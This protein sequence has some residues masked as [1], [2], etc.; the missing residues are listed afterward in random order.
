MIVLTASTQNPPPD[1][2]LVAC[3]AA[4]IPWDCHHNS[5]N[6]GVVQ[7]YQKLWEKHCDESALV[8]MHDDVTIHDANWLERVCLELMAPRVAIVGLG[9]ATGIGLPEIYKTPYRIEQLQRLDYASNQTGWEIHGKQET[10][11]RRVAVVDGFLMAIKGK[12]L[13]EIGGWSWIESNFHCYD[14]AM[15]LE[16]HRRGWEVRMVGVSCEHHGGGTSTKEEYVEFCK[17]RGITVGEDHAAPHRWLY[18]EYRDI[19]PLRVQP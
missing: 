2:F 3:G 17:E 9:G 6:I 15:C 14:T 7:A 18:R 12:F 4:G 10:E 5:P 16:A 13:R 11:E 19:L 8:Y 1:R